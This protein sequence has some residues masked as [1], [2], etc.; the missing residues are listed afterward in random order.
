MRPSRVLKAGNGVLAIPVSRSSKK[1][2][3]YNN[4]KILTYQ[5]VN[6]ANNNSIN[7][8]YPDFTGGVFFA[9]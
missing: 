3:P 9:A 5:D 8:C 6:T 2:S 1:Q 4:Y 7:T